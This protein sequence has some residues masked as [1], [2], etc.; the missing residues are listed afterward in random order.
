MKTLRFAI[1]GTGFWSRYQL[2]GWRGLDGV[3]CVALFNRTKAKGDALAAEFGVPAVYDNAALLLEREK[4]DF[5]DIITNVETHAAFVALAA[6]HQLPAICQKPMADS[7]NAARGMLATC[8]AAGVP[9]LIHENWRWQT[10]LRALK[11]VLDSG[12]L[13]TRSAVLSRRAL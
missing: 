1:L 8:Q 2:A 10:P 11:A 3:E 7:L 12:Q 5:V 6:G 9:L 4:L 13:G